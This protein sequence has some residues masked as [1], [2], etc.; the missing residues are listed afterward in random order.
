MVD[1]ANES[2]L[3]KAVLRSD[4]GTVEKL[5]SHKKDAIKIDQQDQEGKTALMYACE[6]NQLEILKVLLAWDCQINIMDKVRLTLFESTL[7]KPLLQ[8]G[9]TAPMFAAMNDSVFILQEL[10]KHKFNINWQDNLGNHIYDYALSS[11]VR[12]MI[13]EYIKNKVDFMTDK[14]KANLFQSL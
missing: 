11:Q 10:M 12:Q 8:Y 5:F 3:M 2:I 7:I 9:R 14:D 13:L 4:V 6:S 1:K